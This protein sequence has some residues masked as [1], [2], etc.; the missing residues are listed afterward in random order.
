MCSDMLCSS[1]NSQPLDRVMSE[2]R[3]HILT[4]AHKNIPGT[5]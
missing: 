4:P 5:Y 2:V 3:V 1:D